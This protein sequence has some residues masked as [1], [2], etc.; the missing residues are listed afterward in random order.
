M[1]KI[2]L[3]HNKYRDIG[4]EDI[5]VT[6]EIEFLKKYYQV[7]V[8]YFNNVISSYSNALFS[9][10]TQNN[11]MSNKRVTVA[12]KTFDPDLIYVHNTWFKASLGIFREINKSKIPVILKIHNFRF[13]CS[14]YMSSK[15]HFANNA[16]CPKCGLNKK[17]LGIFNKYYEDSYL[18]SLFLILYGRSY[19]K[20]LKNNKMSIL[21]L[22]N[23]QKKYM[24]KIGINKNKI[25]IHRN[26]LKNTDLA[27]E[28]YNP[29][30]NYIV[31]AGRISKEKGVENLIQGFLLS[32]VNNLELKIIGKG[33]LLEKLKRTYKDTRIK[34]YGE[35]DNDRT[36]AFINKSRAVVTSTQLYEGQPTVLCEA[37]VAK[38]PS[39]FPNNG[40]IHEFFPKS[41]ELMYEKNSIEDLVQKIN[42]LENKKLLLKVSNQNKLFIDG[43]LEE[44]TYIQ[45][46]ENIIRK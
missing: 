6:E 33:P 27:E 29:E 35:L 8:L 26:I 15:Y 4:G 39:I 22:T 5:A 30:S 21:V 9:F 16:I 13:S 24:E 36:K 34:F 44:K 20:I 7:E 1:K 3:I 11:I 40:G 2:L 42:K 45:N 31:Y 19:F 14:R 38:V 10:L 23:F 17:N 43:M 18:R 25:F 28:D 37:S 41:Y 32:T 12:I 46:L